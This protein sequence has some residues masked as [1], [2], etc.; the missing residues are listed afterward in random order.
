MGVRP[1]LSASSVG[2]GAATLISWAVINSAT[3]VSIL[4][5]RNSWFSWDLASLSNGIAMSFPPG[6]SSHSFTVSRWMLSKIEVGV[7]SWIGGIGPGEYLSIALRAGC[8]PMDVRSFATSS[9]RSEIVSFFGGGRRVVALCGGRP[10]PRAAWCVVFFSVAVR[11]RAACDGVVSGVGWSVWAGIGVSGSWSFRGR[12]VS[13]TVLGW[14]D[15]EGCC[16][17]DS[18]WWNSGMLMGGGVGLLSDWG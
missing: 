5:R 4:V 17:G 3:A 12:G 10:G 15:G 14:G 7:A 11:S 18:S 6:R 8:L 1:F 2:L 9:S 16:C 13:A